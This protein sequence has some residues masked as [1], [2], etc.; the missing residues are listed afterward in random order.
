MES[1]EGHR[2]EPRNKPP[3]PT[4]QGYL[5]KPTSINNV[6]TLV[7]ALMIAHHGPQQFKD[8]GTFD[9]RGSKVFSVSGDTPNA[10]I[11]E[12]ELG[13]SLRSLWMNLVTAIP[14]PCRWGCIW[15]LR[16]P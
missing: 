6:E 15:I 14:K 1:M 16:C 8:M 9:S 7:F 13:M 12:L 2:G 10:G 11:Y 5:G 3:Y 4:S